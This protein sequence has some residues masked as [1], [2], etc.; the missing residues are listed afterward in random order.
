VADTTTPVA[1]YVD[2]PTNSNTEATFTIDSSAPQNTK[3]N[4]DFNGDGNVD[5]NFGPLPAGTTALY[6][7]AGFSQPIDDPVYQAGQTS[8]VFKAGSTVPVKFQLKKADG[9]IVQAKTLP[10]WLAPAPLSSMSASVDEPVV[11]ATATT[12]TN[13]KWDAVSQQYIYNWSTKGLKSGYWYK[14]SVK[15]DDGSTYNVKVGLK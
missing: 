8:S 2:V 7:F 6:P 14:L 4:V 15:L 12:G 11:T 5:A 10:V 13:F 3:V 1:S 9:T